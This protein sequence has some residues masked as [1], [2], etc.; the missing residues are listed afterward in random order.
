MKPALIILVLLF[1]LNPGKAQQH[2]AYTPPDDPAV[3]QTL[4]QWQYLKFGLFMHWGPYSEWGVV[5]SWS[6]CPED[7]GWTQRKGPFGADYNTYKKAYENL[8][9]TFTPTH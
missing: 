9:P 6:L 4:A 7:E 3:Q 2:A 1:F 5:E 8:Q